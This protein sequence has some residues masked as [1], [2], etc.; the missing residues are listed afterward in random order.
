[1]AHTYESML[2]NAYKQ[3]GIAERSV[4]MYERF[5]KSKRQKCIDLGCLWT[6]DEF[7]MRRDTDMTR[8]QYIAYTNWTT[9]LKRLK[10]S[11]IRLEE[12]QKRLDSLLSIKE[13]KEAEQTLKKYLSDME[14]KLNLVFKGEL[15]PDEFNEECKRDNISFEYIDKDFLGGFDAK[16]RAFTLH[17]NNGG[18]TKSDH[19]YTARVDG[20]VIIISG[21]F[22]A[23]Y[24][25]LMERDSIKVM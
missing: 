14:G 6:E 2:H 11:K 10:T 25:R 22:S 21:R 23:C 5:D 15:S 4:K 20:E 18:H 1:M 9:N 17:I 12:N 19:C 24:K 8:H 16:G 13:Q 7:K 3:V